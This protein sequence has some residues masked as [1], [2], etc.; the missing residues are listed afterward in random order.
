MFW[1]TL[2]ALVLGFA[3]SGAVQAFVSRERM[4]RSLGDHRPAT[5]AKASLWGMVSSSCSYAASALARTLFRRG[6]DFTT[7][8]VFMIASTN[9][10]V[11]MGL[12][13]WLLLSWQFALAEFVG[14]AIMIALIGC[15]GP[16]LFGRNVP[17]TDGHEEHGGH[18]HGGHEHGGHE[19][20]GHEHGGH[21]HGGI[22]APDEPF[23][24]RVRSRRGWA[25]A[26]AFMISDL[27]MLRRELVIGYLVAGLLAVFV[28]VA[29]WQSVFV[30]GHGF[31]SSLESVLVG[32]LLAIVAFVCSVGNVPLAATLWHGGASFGGVIAF[33]FADL[34]ALPLLAIYRR[35]Y[36]IRVT[37]KILALFWAAMSLAGLAVEYLFALMGVP[38]PSHDV[39]L[40]MRGISWNYTTW[41][42]I[43]ALVAFAVLYVLYRTRGHSER[44]AKD[45]VC[46]M[47]VEIAQ[48]PA[49]R[50]LNGET[51]Y[52]CSDR[53]ARSFDRE[54]RPEQGAEGR[55]QEGAHRMASETAIDP[56]CHMT[57][58]VQAAPATAEH[59][60]RTYYFCS[61]GCRAAFAANPAAFVEATP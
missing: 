2:W 55:S 38:E 37:L 50:E 60:G 54:H 47:Q 57:V 20:G 18:E 12:V 52:F 13:L 48:A 3:L 32:P 6:A 31:A 43:A 7:S 19:H 26:A 58:D 44:Y 36:G 56:V 46:G 45:P 5:I 14:G 10:V 27:T 21:E 17:V 40:R 28:P 4:Q 1:D 16:R 39:A 33:V 35:Y 23:G 11:E 22:D 59:D 15:L 49:R 51:Y 61:D 34:I 24:R 30:T 53:C 8:L 41:L 42:N 9:L 25:D 29:V